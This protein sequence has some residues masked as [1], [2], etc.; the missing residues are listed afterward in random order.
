MFTKIAVSRLAL[1]SVAALCAA[2]VCAQNTAY[3]TDNDRNDLVVTATGF[4]LDGDETGQSISV[5]DAD[6]LAALQSATISEALR[7]LPGVAVAGRGPVGSQTSVF[8]RGGNSS[9][10]LVLVDGVR[11]NDPSSPNAAFDFGALMAGTIDRVEI[12]RG[13]NSIIWGSQAIGGVVDVRSAL[14]T[15]GLEGR[16][17]AEYGY[18]DTVRASGT[19]SGGTG[20]VSASLGGAYFRTDGISALAGGT[21]RDGVNAVAFNGRVLVALT[22]NISFD[23]RGYF[24]RARVAYDSPFGAGANALPITQNRQILGYA[25]MNATFADGRWRNRL[26]YTRTDIVRLGTDPVAFSFNNFD[27]AGKIDRFEYHSAFDLSE[28]A[29]LNFGI[30]HERT[31]STVSF[32]GAAADVARNRVTSGFAQ[33]LVRPVTGLALTGGIRHDAYRDYGGQTTL[34]GNIAYSPNDGATVLRATYGE[35]FRAPTL[36]EG[37]PPYGNVNL[38]PETARNLDI[39]V[40]QNL[41]DGQVQLIATYFNRRST[42]LIAFSFIT[43][44]SENI[45]RVEAKGAEISVAVQPTNRLDIRLNYTLTDAINQSVGANFGKRLALRPQNNASLTA[46]WQSPWGAS[47]GTTILMVGDSFDNPSNT[48]RLN[49]YALVAVRAA[50]SL[51]DVLEVYGRIDNLFDSN[52]QTVAGYGSYPRAATVGVRAKF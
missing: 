3:D 2:P 15:S 45:D 21:E 32:E 46:D 43:F 29:T 1:A 25:G 41:L 40:E 13:P 9:Q 12:L 17:S 16:A 34:G 30:E 24:N 23:F 27:V 20:I 19:I 49:G 22:E 31:F 4:E 26:A 5:I 50:M 8:I 35:G 18:A 28:A 6:R 42:D 33:L 51:N 7:T 52:Y 36:T 11:I 48:V 10:T 14:P 39:G 47:V 38:R 37:Q 44:Q